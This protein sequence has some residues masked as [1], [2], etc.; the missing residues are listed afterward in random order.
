MLLAIKPKIIKRLCRIFFPN[1]EEEAVLPHSHETLGCWRE[2]ASYRSSHLTI[3]A[4]KQT[5]LEDTNFFAYTAWNS[6]LPCT[7]CHAFIKFYDTFKTGIV[8]VSQTRH[9]HKV[10]DKS[11]KI[12]SRFNRTYLMTPDADTA[13]KWA[14]YCLLKCLMI[15]HDSSH[16]H[17]SMQDVNTSAWKLCWR[18]AGR[19][20]CI[21]IFPLIIFDTEEV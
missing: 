2:A 16:L 18:K 20:I 3:K 9:L 14:D 21:I 19:Y 7:L 15:Y 11:G 4:I 8:L 1:M 12:N 6:L 17:L 13:D 5:M 10:H